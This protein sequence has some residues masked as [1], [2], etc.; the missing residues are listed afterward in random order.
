MDP[1]RYILIGNPD[2]RRVRLFQDELAARGHPP[3]IEIAYRDLL[4]DPGV[5]DQ[6]PDEPFL[7]RQDSAGED[8]EVERSLLALGYHDAVAADV[9]TIDPDAIA[10]LEFDLGRIL[11]PRQLHLGFLRLLDTLAAIYAA[12]PSWRILSPPPA[13]AELFDKRV[14]SR[15][16]RE[17]GI[18]VPPGLSSGIHGE[19]DTDAGPD[20]VSSPDELRQAM[21]ERDWPAVYVKVS[22]SSSA[23]CLAVYHWQR[24]RDVRRDSGP[25]RG[26]LMT[27]IEHTPGAWYNSLRIRR[28]REPARVDEILGFLLRE[29]AQ[30]EAQ[31]AKARL[32]GAPFD[33]RIVAVA[34]EPAHGV[35]RQNRHPI[36]NLHLGGW[37]GDWPAL[38][39]AMPAGAL[40]AVYHSCRRVAAASGCFSLG[41]DVLVEP[42]M[43]RHRILEA[44]A[45]GDLLPNLLRDGLSVYGWQIREAAGRTW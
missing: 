29:G 25:E 9:D 8:F 15:R 2:N 24:S 14:T 21:D 34:G 3:A 6:L 33:L 23:S 37:R 10:A 27:T 26:W 43:A 44:N 22:C 5:L 45:F 41:I 4:R 16:W 13:I 38:E 32:D 18:P 1:L 35:V 36:T 12:H 7:V 28:Y 39:A 40:D 20:R 30:I 19:L 11:C 17:L 31:V 42:G